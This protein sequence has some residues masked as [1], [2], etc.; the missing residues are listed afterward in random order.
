VDLPGEDGQVDSAQRV[1]P[2]EALR[3]AAQ[4]QPRLD[5]VRHV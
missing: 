1:R 4:R 5:R 2:P 3:E